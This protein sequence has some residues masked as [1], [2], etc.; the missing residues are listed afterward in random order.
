MKRTNDMNNMADRVDMVHTEVVNASVALKPAP[1][2]AWLLCFAAAM[3][4]Q[5][6]HSL[7]D[8]LAPLLERPSHVRPRIAASN[9]AEDSSRYDPT[10]PIFVEFDR[11]MDAPSAEAAFS[12]SGT[13]SP[14]GTKR[15]DGN[16]LVF[17][18]N[19]PL[20]RG[21]PL[22]LRVA[23]SARSAEAHPL[24]TEFIVHFVPGSRVDAPVVMTSFPE[25]NATGV[26]AS[27]VI[28]LTF[29]RPMN[30]RSVEKAVRISPD[31][32]GLFSWSQ[33]S[34][35]LTVT[36]ADGLAVPASYSVSLSSEA[37]DAEGIRLAAPFSLEFQTGSDF[38][39]PLVE[40]VRESSSIEP[41]EEDP[42]TGLFDGISKDS[43]FFITFSEPMSP[44]RTAG[45]ITLNEASDD[46][47]VAFRPGWTDFR[48]LTI[49][50]EAPLDP[51]TTYRLTVTKAAE[52]AAGNSLLT[53]F[54]RHMRVS[55][56][57]GAVNSTYVVATHAAQ[58]LSAQEIALDPFTTTTL[59]LTGSDSSASGAETTIDIVF[60][61]TLDPSSVSEAI[62]ITRRLGIHPAAGLLA[63]VQLRDQAGLPASVLRLAFSELGARNEYS[64]SLRG[65][66]S[67]LRSAA[68]PGET[69]T[70]QKL[71]T[72]FHIRVE[73]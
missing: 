5:C 6:R 46:R 65:G 20:P 22:T 60:S 33:G 73:P 27:S 64:I 18:P 14:E 68:R 70:W 41:I 37:C 7:S 34:T 28:A 57:L 72:I 4:I 59:H 30:T 42:V 26:E 61:H 40:S 29:S 52:D 2:L 50:P 11:P 35:V 55:N 47:A 49:S 31:T 63:G 9:P 56:A 39:R 51:D 48:H 71:D 12:L 36:P 25:R 8:T 3:P 16:R 15:W 54:V 19:E 43:S 21:I 38:T 58:S 13:T 32:P 62:S 44:G 24:Q 17:Q 1:G 67:G 23:G 45:S 66:R 69:F 10:R 53:P